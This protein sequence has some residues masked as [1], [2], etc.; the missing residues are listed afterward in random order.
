M[1]EDGDVGGE[2]VVALALAVVR[3]PPMVA[4]GRPMFGPPDD[5]D[6]TVVNGIRL[7][8]A[9]DGRLVAVV[10]PPPE[11]ARASLGCP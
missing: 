2:P 11:W 8:R 6:G 4:F 5:A 10:E 3:K 7:W 1:G 9:P